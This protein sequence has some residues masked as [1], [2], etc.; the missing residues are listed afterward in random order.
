MMMTKYNSK[1]QTALDRLY[2]SFSLDFWLILANVLAVS[3]WVLDSTDA[4]TLLALPLVA[5]GSSWAF[6]NK[7]RHNQTIFRNFIGRYKLTGV[8]S[9]LLAL[10]TVLTV[11]NFA[12][13]PSHAFI[14]NE[15]GVGRV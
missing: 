10:V 4:L 6:V 1:K 7:S 3:N 5:F 9:L 15:T 2:Y 12:T 13:S 11:F 8:L 14:V